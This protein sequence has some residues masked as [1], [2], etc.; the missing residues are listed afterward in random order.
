LPG[1]V[2]EHPESEHALKQFYEIFSPF[3]V[4]DE[5]YFGVG[6]SPKAM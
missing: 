5:N 6:L 2:V 4:S 1:A 3:P